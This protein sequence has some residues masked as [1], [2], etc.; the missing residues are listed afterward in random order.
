MHFRGE[1]CFGNFPIWLKK[2]KTLNEVPTWRPRNARNHAHDHCLSSFLPF[3]LQEQEHFND[4]SGLGWFVFFF[5]AELP[6][7]SDS[8][9]KL[10]IMRGFDVCC[11]VGGGCFTMLWMNLMSPWKT[12]PCLTCCSLTPVG[13]MAKYSSQNFHLWNRKGHLLQAMN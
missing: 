7:M 8:E 4:S 11:V 9:S 5:D 1:Q 2:Y 12:S 6:E 13:K 10:H 3:L